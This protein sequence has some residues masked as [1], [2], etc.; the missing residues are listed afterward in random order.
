MKFMVFQKDTHTLIYMYILSFNIL[1][2]AIFSGAKNAVTYLTMT[3]TLYE[4]NIIIKILV[5]IKR[6]IIGM[7]A[8]TVLLGGGEL[9]IVQI[10]LNTSFLSIKGLRQIIISLVD[11][12]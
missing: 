10:F 8:T 4:H 6:H 9:A 7:L 12:L 11:L 2:Y 1:S 3:K 5:G